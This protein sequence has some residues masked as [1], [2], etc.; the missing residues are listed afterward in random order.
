MEV[1]TSL[2]KKE[3]RRVAEERV[4]NGAFAKDFTALDTE[5]PGVEKALEELYAKADESD[6]AQGEARVRARLGLNANGVNGSNGT[7]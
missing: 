6:L 4:L 5:G 2:I 7:H 3:F 1:D